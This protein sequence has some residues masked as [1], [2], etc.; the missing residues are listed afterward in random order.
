[1]RMVYWLSTTQNKIHKGAYFDG[2]KDIATL[3][4][5]NRDAGPRKGRRVLDTAKPYAELPTE[6]LEQGWTCCQRCFPVSKRRASL[7][8]PLADEDIISW[9]QVKAELDAAEE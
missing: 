7:T 2:V 8:D 5:C 4:A 9:E 1:M 3:E 6:L